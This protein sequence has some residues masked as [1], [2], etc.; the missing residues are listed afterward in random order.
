MVDH[1]LLSRKL[2]N[3]RSYVRELQKADDINLDI[4]ISDMRSRAFVERCL[5]LAI[6]EVIDIA[7]HL[8]AF[9]H[10]REPSGYRDMFLVLHEEGVI[11]KEQL[12][13][14]QDMASFRN[15]LVHRYER[16]DNEIV[17]GL[18]K[19]RLPDFELFAD[20]ITTWANES[21]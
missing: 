9:H 11:P 14:F 21:N 18:F 16:I 2:S 1:A 3:L 13:R 19:T 20:L 8:I 10:W 15:M 5:H 4:Y 7:N 17:Y 6:E 12:T